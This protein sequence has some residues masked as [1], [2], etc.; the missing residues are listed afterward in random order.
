ME[1]FLSFGKSMHLK[2]LK[3]ALNVGEAL[4]ESAVAP[5]WFQPLP[6]P[7]PPS[8]QESLCEVGSDL[9][10]NCLRTAPS[11]SGHQAT[12][13]GAAIP[14]GLG[15]GGPGLCRGQKWAARCPR[16]PGFLRVAARGHAFG[17][18]YSR[19]P[20]LTLWVFPARVLPCERGF[21]LCGS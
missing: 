16:S 3:T 2:M 1:G 18:V 9:G 15:G 11:C 8:F 4:S 21:H 12:G 13:R 19:C 5:V 14:V 17:K 7:L 20:A 6:G 10:R